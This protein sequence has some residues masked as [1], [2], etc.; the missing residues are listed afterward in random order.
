VV[1]RVADYSCLV[2]ASYGKRLKGSEG[3]HLEPLRSRVRT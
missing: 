3:D 1:T 2:C